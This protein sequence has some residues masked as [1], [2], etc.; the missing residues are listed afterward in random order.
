MDYEASPLER[1]T[2]TYAAGNSWVG[3]GIGVEQQYMTNTSADA[4]RIWTI[5]YNSDFTQNV[6]VTSAIY[7]EG[8]L[9]KT[10]TINEQ[11]NQ[12]VEY[13][14]KSGHVILK[15]VELSTI[16]ADAY[17]GWLSTYYVY[18]DF[19]SLRFVISPRA[20][21]LIMSNWLITDVNV[22]NELC[23]RYEYDGR[24]RM[25]AKK[26]PGA[27]W[28]NL[29]YDKRDRQV[30]TQD[31]NMAILHQ[32]HVTL[33]DEI[34]RP[35]LT[36]M[37]TYTGSASDLQAYVDANTI[38]GG[39]S[40]VTVNG[41]VSGSPQ[42]NIMLNQLQQNVKDYRASNSITFDVGFET[43]NSTDLIAQIVNTSSQA[44]TSTVSVNNNPLPPGT[45]LV[46]LTMS[47]YDDYQWTNKSYNI[48]NN[49]QLDPGNN[50]NAVNL[51]SQAF[52]NTR[53]V[54]TGTAVR[55]LPDPS[56]LSS[57]KWMS[58]VSYYDDHGRIIQ[59]QSE[60]YKGGL[61][62]TTN[63]YNFS[64]ALLCNYHV[65]SNPQVATVALQT[66]KVKTNMEYEHAGHLLEVWKSINDAPKKLVSKSEYD[67][68]GQ[69][70]KKLLGVNPVTSD[71]LETLDYAYNIRGWLKGINKDYA[72]GVLGTDRWF[73]AELNYDWGFDN[74]Q[75]NGNIG[76]TKWRSKGDGEKRSYGFGYD[77]AN[78]LLYGDFAQVSGSSYSDNTIYNFDVLMGD[79]IDPLKAYDE[80]GNIL[81]MQQWGLKVNSSSQIDN[82][83]YTYEHAG[84][85]NKLLNVV[86]LNN[87]TGT[88]LGDFK[89]SANHPQL[90]YKNTVGRDPNTI[91]DYTYDNNG[92]LKKDLNKDIGNATVDGI[93][94]N[95]LN[96]PW[97]ITVKTPTGEKGTITYIY[98]AAGNKLEK[99]VNETTSTPKTTNTC[100]LGGFIYE[101]NEL[102]FFSHE[103]GRVRPFI[104]PHNAIVAWN[105][106]YFVKD[107]LGNVRVVL[108]E[109]Q[110][111]DN[112]PAVTLE[113]TG[114]PT[115]PI[116]IEKQFYLIDEANV[117]LKSEA[118]G[119]TDY[120]NNNG[121]PPVN[122]NPNCNDNSTIKQTDLSQ[123]LY[124]L[125]GSTNKTGLGITLKVMS[126]DHI[127]I[128]G[129]SYYIQNNTGGSGVN[130][131]PL[132]SEIISGLLGSP[133]GVTAGK[134]TAADLNGNSTGTVT[135]INNF[136]NDPNRSDPNGQK[137]K[138]YINYILLDEHFQFVSGN[139][140]AVGDNSM[141]KP[142]HHQD[143]VLQN[144]PV[145]KN[146]YL[147]VYA[148]NE[149]PVNVYFDN[150]Q[151]IHTR[152]PL[153]EE[154]HY[155]P[156]GLTMAGISSK[157]AGGI[158]NKLKYNGK[159]E[160]RHE[161]S[162]CSGLEWIDY[163]AR[164]YDNQIER[165]NTID[166]LSQQF[167]RETP[168]NYAGNNP[169][170][171]VDVDG[172][173]RLSKKTEQFLKQH[174]PKF[175]K[176][177]TS[178]DGILKM[179]TNQKLLSAFEKLGYSE[180]NVI[181]DYTPGSGAEIRTVG[182]GA[183]YRGETPGGYS[184]SVIEINT[185]VLDVLEG[186]K[187]PE[188]MEAGLL[189]V[190]EVLTHEE[191]HRASY[192]LGQKMLGD[193]YDNPNNYTHQEDGAWLSEQVWGHLKGYYGFQAPANDNPNF[194][195]ILLTFA[196]QMIKNQKEEQKPA[197]EPE[198][199][200]PL[201][202]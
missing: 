98:D 201:C 197:P 162:D 175:Y 73:G 91:T 105:Y 35:I 164:M 11:S 92:N 177:I 7:D 81:Q 42:A 79:G 66:I 120:Q 180:N 37:I 24:K 57:G 188:E 75:L 123:K 113:G 30:F 82:L 46:G 143:A 167:P 97:R 193:K 47:Y 90:A 85:S 56:D 173:F 6:P 52:S 43:D 55:T 93:I 179:S 49:A 151:V 77:K 147:Y 38:V 62:I 171:N 110:Q 159:E 135:P 41:S 150:L 137:P 99:I 108:T 161:F 60:N 71:P 53:G 124:R 45:T 1:P 195:Q 4:V 165:F 131:T 118:T 19:G 94:Y 40:D 89:T 132:L 200:Q 153:L 3:S 12:V 202:W 154:T 166:P 133:T 152:G 54:L 168:Y 101:N 196:M 25:I 69:Q 51:P 176:Y 119:I 70:T 2:K 128:F 183:F 190:T 8:Q 112:Y 129:K 16:H 103:E 80:N 5:D 111:Q 163:G 146:G 76:G 115:D 104:V 27:G 14:D 72:N 21:K 138:A 157:A 68:I 187:T 107:H 95:H 63:Q 64:G 199:I 121:N 31:A 15:K 102:Q 174:Y 158:E 39:N 191:G 17:D 13:K 130:V 23:F 33:Y 160:Q 50:L 140:S 61:D 144:I 106:D 134:A 18:D 36:G 148:S 10:I 185:K 184:G 117:A 136:L 109:Q 116:A 32:W 198:P 156:F 178:K 125:N 87:D 28:V 83:I 114:Q 65:Q 22:I 127:D 172:M 149:S 169:I 126:G 88:K 139:F 26:V 34:N 141:V 192:L 189:S 58:T 155:Y 122:N 145:T 142:Q 48:A 100:Y 44:F 78:R 182:K 194:V 29:I 20:V 74:N 9:T 170:S 67:A 84:V 186:T 59:S 86:D 181:R 96:L